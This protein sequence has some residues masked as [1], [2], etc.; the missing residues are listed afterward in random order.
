MWALTS[1]ANC[2]SVILRRLRFM[3]RDCSESKLKARKSI[4]QKLWKNILASIPIACVD[5][6]VH[7][8]VKR[9]T[10]VL[11]GYRKI[12]PYGDIWALPGGRII[13]K[14][15]LRD[16]ANR[17]LREIGLRPSGKYRLVG[18][19]PVNLKHRS[20][21]TISLS[22]HLTSSQEPRPTKELVKYTWRRLND[23]SSR[24]GSNYGKML[25]DFKNQHYKV[26]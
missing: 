25:R 17:Q 11:L 9:E 19:Y 23:L 18:V 3:C 5:V 12:Y 21:I 6:I 4:P 16:T 8:K 7:R 15:S 20:D 2:W 1:T 24:L 26:R 14:E 22:T 13:K 10:R